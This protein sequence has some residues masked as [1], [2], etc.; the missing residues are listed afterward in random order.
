MWS[1]K[2]TTNTSVGPQSGHLEQLVKATTETPTVRVIGALVLFL[3]HINLTYHR[4]ATGRAL[5]TSLMDFADT[6]S[7][8]VL[9]KSI[10]AS[11]LLAELG[12]DTIP[13]RDQVHQNLDDRLLV[14]RERLPTNWLKD[15]QV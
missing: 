4:L 3:R 8:V 14:P 7:K 15:Y 6:I 11:N 13:S 9:P 2:K 5:G 1:E 12:L 10:D